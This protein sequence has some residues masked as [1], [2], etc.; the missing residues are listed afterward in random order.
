MDLDEQQLKY[1]M[2]FI[3]GTWQA[4][5]L[6][7][8][9]SSDSTHIPACEFKSDDGTDFSAFSF[10]F[11][12]DHTIVVSDAFSGKEEYGTWEQT[13]SNEYHYCLSNPF[14]VPEDEFNNY[15]ETLNV[16]NGQLSFMIENLSV[17]MKKT[18]EGTITKTQ[19]IGDMES[20]Q[21]MT[22]II[23]NYKVV[24]VMN[25]ETF[26]MRTKEELER[27]KAEGKIDDETYSEA[28]TFFE[29]NIEF[30]SD[31]NVVTMVKGVCE[32]Q[33]WKAVDGKYYINT[34]EE[35]EIYGEKQSPWKEIEFDEDGLIKFAEGMLL[36]QKVPIQGCK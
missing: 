22:D 11:F 12:E 16:Q 31:G 27:Q 25:F 6:V 5:F 7:N 15:A 17:V 32:T 29:M 18:A 21:S 23:G 36:L 26:E 28:L 24:K 35:V 30:T 4:D 33:D 2:E 13:G 19:D 1:G 14:E 3:V 9:F 34:N 10:E 8:T 20:D